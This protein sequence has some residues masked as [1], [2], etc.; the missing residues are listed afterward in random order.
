MQIAGNNNNNNNG[1]WGIEDED[2][3]LEHS[4]MDYSTVKRRRPIHNMS[5]QQHP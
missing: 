2:D 3:A 1:E 4:A 5:S